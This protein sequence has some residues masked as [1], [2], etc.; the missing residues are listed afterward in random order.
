[1]ISAIILTKNEEHMISNCINSCKQVADEI[2]II[3][4]SST[5]RTIE[6]A[7]QKGAK[8]FSSTNPSFAGR[9]DEGA[10][11]AS[12]EWLLYVDADERV[13]PELAQEIK[14]ITTQSNAAAV[15]I[16]DRKD[17]YFG[18]PRPLSS[19]MHRL[20]KKENLTSW[21]GDL[22]ETP[23]V[24]G[25]SSKLQNYLLH[26]TH[27]DID[28]MLRNTLEWST[29]EAQLRISQNH[30]PIVWWRLIRV[31]A[32]GFW[33]S[34][35]TQQGYKC[36]TA[37]WVEAMYQGFSLF[38]TYAKV[39]EMQNKDKIRDNYNELDKSFSNK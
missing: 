23:Q 31:F 5:D 8:I 20:M 28:S 12:G 32:T 27:L 16:I 25:D 19:P 21:V 29:K 11:Q 30:P 37:G 3:D 22:H 17:F 36:G 15:Y 33:N 2:I 18:G 35:V 13:T 39:W 10:Q 1:M 38:L 9:R 34:F 24:T 26:F 7:T 14:N 4:N 6:I